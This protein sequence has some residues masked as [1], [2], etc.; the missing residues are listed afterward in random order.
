MVDNF[1]PHFVK[2][3]IE[4]YVLESLIINEFHKIMNLKILK[5]NN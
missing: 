5:K 2:Q 3:K 1:Y 4:L